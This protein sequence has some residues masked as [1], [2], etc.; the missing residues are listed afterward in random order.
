[1]LTGALLHQI[2]LEPGDQTEDQ[3]RQYVTRLFTGVGLLQK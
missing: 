1:M 2:L 3:V